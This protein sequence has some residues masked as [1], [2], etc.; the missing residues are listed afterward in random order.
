[1][2]G[3]E[4]AGHAS[5]FLRLETTSAVN[6]GSPRLQ[7]FGQ[8]LQQLELDGAELAKLLLEMRVGG[9]PVQGP[10]GKPEGIVTQADLLRAFIKLRGEV[11]R[12]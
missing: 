6:Q 7:L 1:M 9:A 8:P 3:E 11:S 4:L 10:D 12:K 2:P 5:V